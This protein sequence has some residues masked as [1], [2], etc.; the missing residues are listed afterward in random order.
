MVIYK[1]R[2]TDLTVATEEQLRLAELVVESWRYNQRM[3]A[4]EIEIWAENVAN[5][6]SRFT[7]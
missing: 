2:A 7:D 3:T 5:Y 4:S 6:Y 1:D